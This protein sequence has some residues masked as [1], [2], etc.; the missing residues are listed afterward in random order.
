MPPSTLSTVPV[1]KPLP[2]PSRKS[3][4]SSSSP[5]RP[6][7]PSGRARQQELRELLGV[8]AELRRHLRGE[9]P[10]GHGVDANPVATPLRRELSRQPDD[11]RLG[12]DVGGVRDL[13]DRAQAHDR[14]DVDDRAPASVSV[15]HPLRGEARQS[16][17]GD[18]V[19]IEH[20]RERLGRR[21]QRGGG[22]SRAR[23]VDEPVEPPVALDDAVDEAFPV[24]FVGDVADD[25]VRVGDIPRQRLEALG[26]ARGQDRD[27]PGGAD[28]ARELRAEAGARARDDHDLTVHRLHADAGSRASSAVSS[29]TRRRLTST[30]S[31]TRPSAPSARE[32]AQRLL[33][34]AAM[35]EVRLDV[36]HA[37]GLLE[38][39]DRPLTLHVEGLALDLVE[40]A[41]EEQRAG[42]ERAV[43]RREHPVRERGEGAPGLLRIDRRRPVGL[44]HELRQRRL[45]AE[46]VQQH[47]LLGLA[48][49]QPVQAVDV[50]LRHHLVLLGAE[51]ERLARREA[52]HREAPR[53][54]PLVE[55]A[56]DVG[57]RDR[58]IGVVAEQRRHRA[59]QPPGPCARGPACSG[60]RT[61]PDSSKV[62]GRTG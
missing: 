29:S 61:P 16:E 45:A 56:V 39:S 21:A 47:G 6:P 17:R 52:Q 25:G 11:A 48:G 14:S 15:A 62:S 2:V 53:P 12:R 34:P 55:P 31:R 32:D 24:G 59:Q 5:V 33:A 57:L 35:V 49:T 27:A 40:H 38:D 60:A 26:T 7:R 36:A 19:E 9:E 46:A 54:R 44:E 51:R 20:V 13:A 58:A 28:R 41:V 18:Q 4:A 23:V 50:I 42:A 8:L 22:G 37:R 43:H 3:T 1:T 30:R 10:G